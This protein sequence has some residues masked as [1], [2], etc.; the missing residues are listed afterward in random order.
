[1]SDSNTHPAGASAPI[2][3]DITRFAALS[4]RDIA[5]LYSHEFSVDLTATAGISREEM[6]RH[7]IGRPNAAADLE[8]LM[9]E[10]SARSIPR[11]FAR[12]GS[13]SPGHSS[14]SSHV[15]LI[16]P[17]VGPEN[18]TNL[19]D[20]FISLHLRPDNTAAVKITI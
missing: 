1:M 3:F 14:L 10:V 5:R 17:A 8:G 7:L 2:E 16:S 15:S 6:L 11:S 20:G 12:L 19:A 18:H 13:R 9:V 4:A